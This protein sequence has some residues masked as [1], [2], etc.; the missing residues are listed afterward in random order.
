[1]NFTWDAFYSFGETINKVSNPHNTDNAKYLAALDAVIAPPGTIVSVNG[2]N[3]NVSGSIVCWVT[4]QAQYRDLYPGC[5]P[6]NITNPGGPSL[7][8]FNYLH[9][10]TFWALEQHMHNV[11]GSIGGGLFGIGLPA[12]EI[13]ANLSFDARWST[14]DMI[15][16]ASPTETVNCTGLR[17][18]LANGLPNRWVQNTNAPVSAKNDVVEAALEVNVPLL[19]DLPF[20]QDVSTNLA[21]RYTKY[22]SFSCGRDLEGWPQ[23]AG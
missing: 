23:L 15:S 4:T 22:S 5:V 10:E 13:R 1:M 14:Y 6:L 7:S 12:G 8:A 20:A 16:N 19:A 3:T 18:C 17:M 2:V 11:G 9:S 21:G